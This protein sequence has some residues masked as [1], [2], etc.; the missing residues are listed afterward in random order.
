[1]SIRFTLKQEQ[2]FYSIETRYI[3]LAQNPIERDGTFGGES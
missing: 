3:A 1:M 2:K